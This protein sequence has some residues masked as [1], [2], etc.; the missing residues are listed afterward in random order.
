MKFIGMSKLFL[1]I[2]SKLKNNQKMK[3]YL[4]FALVALIVVVIYDQYVRKMLF[5]T[6]PVKAK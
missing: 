3:E 1:K 6:V 2:W 4:K 5:T